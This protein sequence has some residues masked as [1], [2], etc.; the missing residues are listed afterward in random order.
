[1]FTIENI[2]TAADTPIG[3][4][5]DS[6][7][8]IH[9][10]QDLDDLIQHCIDQGMTEWGSEMVDLINQSLAESNFPLLTIINSTENT[11]TGDRLSLI[12]ENLGINLTSTE[13]E[14]EDLPE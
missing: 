14:F 5:A 1:M 10:I 7:T 12:A 2:E 9:S 11:K 8:T 4:S 13:G 6:I 3:S